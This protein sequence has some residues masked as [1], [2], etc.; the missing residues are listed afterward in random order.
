MTEFAISKIDAARRQLECAIR[1][2]FG[3]SD[4]IAIHTLAAAARNMLI[5]LCIHRGAKS[6][7]FRDGLVERYV[8][9]EHHAT[10]RA[11][12]RRA[13]NFSEHAD[14]DP[15]GLLSFTQSQ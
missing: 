7:I 6:D 2:Y 1:L 12:Y 5:D 15:D 11:R 10:V 3:S 14:R 4:A 13:E 8:K 9:P